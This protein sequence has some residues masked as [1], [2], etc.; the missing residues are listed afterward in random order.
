MS[1]GPGL[2][3][4]NL[5]GGING[6]H[7]VFSNLYGDNYIIQQVF[8]THPK[9]L[10]IDGLRKMFKNDNIYTYR[11]DEFGYPL[12]V[13]HTDLDPDSEDLTKILISDLYRYEVKHYPAI[14]VRSNGGSSRPVSINQN[15]TI[16][17]R[18]DLVEND[19]GARR[20]V[21][22]PTHRVYA[23]FWELN[24]D[25]GVYAQSHT[26]MEELTEMVAI[27]LQHT[28]REELR[29]NG[30]FI[31]DISIGGESAEDY[32]NSHIYSQIISVPI[33]SE[34]RVEIPLENIVEKVVF[35]FQ[36]TMTPIP[37]QATQKDLLEMDYEEIIRLSEVNS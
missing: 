21:S 27:L 6:D 8:H 2:N 20:T 1:N 10:L 17:Y 9:N 26:E 19:L 11:E 37:G 35:F 24:F 25:V 14:T 33:L 29:A 18:K 12:T 4:L 30:I 32:G 22:T 3:I 13:D 34:W 23:G 5:P 31:K 28:L 36:S 15:G 7:R 16:R